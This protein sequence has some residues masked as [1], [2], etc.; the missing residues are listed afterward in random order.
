VFDFS[1]ANEG[2]PKFRIP[3]GN[4]TL[5]ARWN[6]VFGPKL[7]MNTT[8]TY[9]SDYSFAFQPI[10][11]SSPSSCSAG[12]KDYGLKVDLSHYPNSRHRLKYGG[13][14]IYHIYTTSTVNVSSGDTHFNI[15]TPPKTCT[16]TRPRSM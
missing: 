13:Q 12:I 1:G 5:A 9:L 16:P 2:D 7:F 4:A 10:R 6:H 11:T 14:Y 3:W 8:A 15:D